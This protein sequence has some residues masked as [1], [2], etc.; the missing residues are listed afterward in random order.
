MTTSPPH[1]FPPRP[2]ILDFGVARSAEAD[3]VMSMQ[4]QAGQIVGTLAYMSPEQVAGS[5]SVNARTDVYALGVMLYELLTRRLPHNI[6]VTSIAEA[7]RAIQQDD[8][9]RPSSIDHTLRGD[10]ETIV[11]KAIERDPAR[12]YGS[13]A[14][15][16]ADI[17]NFLADR[18]IMARPP[19]KAY[20]FAKFA[21]RHTGLVAGA[22]AAVVVL[23]A[24]LAVSLM[25]YRQAEAA[26]QAASEQLTISKAAQARAEGINTFLVQDLIDSTLAHDDARNTTLHDALVRAADGIQTR[27]A[28]DA[29]T[30]SGLQMQVGSMLSRFGDEEKARDMLLPAWKEVEARL[31]PESGEAIDAKPDMPWR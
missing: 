9:A 2:K 10:L 11:L 19:T 13:A 31:G 25:L 7:A 22:T 16:A 6:S 8:P 1:L 28:N 4:T 15:L 20:L 24:G 29:V 23:I 18:P 30:R 27:F 21:R 26:R 14:A 17:R 12:R 5:Q 3:P